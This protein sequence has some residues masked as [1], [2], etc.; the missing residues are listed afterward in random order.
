MNQ[1]RY[2]D[3]KQMSL[4]YDF[5]ENP[6]DKYLSKEPKFYQPRRIWSHNKLMKLAFFIT[7]QIY[8]ATCLKRLYELIH[9]NVYYSIDQT[10]I[11]IWPANTGGG[12]HGYA[13]QEIDPTN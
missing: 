4:H 13:R 12:L 8:T 2:E 3:L 9:N 5:Y 1:I 10:N 6:K 11:N 7:C